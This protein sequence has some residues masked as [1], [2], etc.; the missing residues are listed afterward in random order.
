MLR[1]ILYSLC[2]RPGVVAFGVARQILG[3]TIV[4]A[5]IGLIIVLAG[6]TTGC[7]R[8]PAAVPSERASVVGTT[9]A[10][11]AARAPIATD[12]GPTY[13]AT[14]DFNNDHVLDVVTANQTHADVSVMLGHG[15]GTFGAK[16]NFGTNTGSVWVESADVNG[17][18]NADLVVGNI[19]SDSVSVLLGMGDGNFGTATNIM[20]GAQPLEGALADF[21]SDHHIDIAVLCFGTNAI[22]VLLGDGA[23]HFGSPMSYGTDNQPHA[24]D[25]GDFNNDHHIDL[26]AANYGEN[27][28]RV[29]L[30]NGDGTFASGV[31]H[32]VDDG[33]MSIVLGDL[34]NDHNL[35]IISADEYAQ[36]VAVL[37]GNGDG[38]FAAAVTVSVPSVYGVALGDFD[39]DSHID[40]VTSNSADNS[41]SILAGDGTGM[42]GAATR[43][44]AGNSPFSVAAGNF[45]GD[46][47]DDFVVA[48]Y[49]DNNIEA[50]TQAASTCGLNEHVA[51]HACVACAV[52]TT[53]AAGD[54]PT[55]ADT[56][57]TTL[58]LC[59][60][61][62]HVLSHTCVMCMPPYVR[63][64]GDNPGGPDTLCM[65]PPPCVANEY[66][67]AHVCVACPAHY[68]NPAGDDPSGADT[69]CTADVCVADDGDACT[70]DWCEDGVAVHTANIQDDYNDCTADICA[71][72]ITTHPTK[73]NGTLCDD[74]NICTVGSTC[75]SGVCSGGMLADPSDGIACTTDSCDPFTG[76]SHT[77]VGTGCLAACASTVGDCSMSGFC[78]IP[79]DTVQHCGGCLI[80]CDHVANAT[81]SCI[82]GACSF[83][84][85]NSGYASCDGDTT[86]GCET[87][88]AT[89]AHN[90][91]ACGTTCSGSCVAGTCV[92][93]APTCAT[94]TANC[95]GN[96]ANGCETNTNTFTDCGACGNRCGGVANGTFSC[97]SGTC[98]PTCK[99]GFFA[100]GN[101]C[102]ACGISSDD[103]DACTT[104]S[105]TSAGPTHTVISTDDQNPCTLDFCDP[106]DGV[107]HTPMPEGT[108]CGTSGLC[109]FGN[110]EFTIQLPDAGMPWSATAGPVAVSSTGGTATR[111][112]DGGVMVVTALQISTSAPGPSEILSPTVLG[113]SN[114]QLPMVVH[115]GPSGTSF[116]PPIQVTVP[117]PA[118]NAGP[119]MALG[120][121]NSWV[122]S[123]I[124]MTTIYPVSAPPSFVVT[125]PHL[126]FIAFIAPLD[127]VDAGVATDA[128]IAGDGSIGSDSGTAGDSSVAMTDGGAPSDAGVEGDSDV[129]AA[130][131]GSPVA[132]K[133]G[134]S[135][136][137]VGGDSRGSFGYFAAALCGA[138]VI[139]RRARRRAFGG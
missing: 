101:R 86:N 128:G 63:A 4:R 94:G 48:N 41:A 24:L 67:S 78:D 88:V 13:V 32:V 34:N 6:I 100:L 77:P 131:A 137:S 133:S 76:F 50:F 14:A 108:A 95:D 97:I 103:H 46:A 107:R 138:L 81:A 42:L 37:L 91:G 38:S 74:G 22:N 23:G 43:Y 61:N 47:Y 120:C 58:P 65:S 132:K 60:L 31:D 17:D 59:T 28:V 10:L 53:R 27:T 30:G 136:S 126:S 26:V 9:S 73:P 129:A 123:H 39:G 113:S 19:A 106:T 83:A 105:C 124:P 85:C 114:Q 29:F 20:V 102:L 56:S 79:V 3:R 75:R 12:D 54:D 130:D 45:D 111:F 87:N 99:S 16:T 90:C 119:V 98:V 15:D 104:D 80:V 33:P 66:V 68:S 44:A 127:D 18:N 135:V 72:G 125:V 118:T 8:T 1:G 70:N 35:D 84:A 25:A 139:S 69:S 55:G 64:A 5:L 93:A 57:C 49:F 82:A 109:A 21:N 117:A 92:G 40:V 71:G 116:S 7:T 89:D 121:D 51:S 134:C 110:C 2:S 115:A 122:C 112:A 11:I 36:S 52:G 62:Q 96:N